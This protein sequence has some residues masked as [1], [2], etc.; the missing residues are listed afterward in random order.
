MFY[1]LCSFVWAVSGLSEDERLQLTAYSN[2][3]FGY[4]IPVIIMPVVVGDTSA[5]AGRGF[6]QQPPTR[7]SA[8]TAAGPADVE[9]QRK[10]GPPTPPYHGEASTTFPPKTARG[11]PRQDPH[12]IV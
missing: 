8:P 10:A 2:W 1:L 9:G 12:F 5:A 4:S 6:Y 3:D 11:S 7:P